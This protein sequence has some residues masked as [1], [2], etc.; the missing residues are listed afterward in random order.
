MIPKPKICGR[1]GFLR[2]PWKRIGRKVYCVTCCSALDMLEKLEIPPEIPHGR[3]YCRKQAKRENTREERKHNYSKIRREYIEKHPTCEAHLRKCTHVATDVHHKKGR[4]KYI[5]DT[6]KFLAVC[7]SCHDWIH[8]H[9][10]I[11][12]AMGLSESRLKKDQDDGDRQTPGGE[13]GEELPGGD[14]KPSG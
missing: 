3:E 10:K 1:C 4:G 11:A 12:M 8:S 6:T 2:P 9:P 5:V 13:T 7:R 14:F